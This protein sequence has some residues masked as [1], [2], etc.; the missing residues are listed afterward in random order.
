MSIR[1]TR[2]SMMMDIATIVAERSTCLRRQVGVVIALEGRILSMGYNGAPSG[3]THCEPRTCNSNAPC[4]NAIHAEANAIAWAA[5]H[6]V[7][8]KGAELYVTLSPCLSC[9]QL[10]VNSGV[11]RVY[12]RSLYRDSSGVVLIEDAGID[13]IHMP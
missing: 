3:M 12:Y 8:L 1:I 2:E 11:Q 4:T 5:R 10:I 13:I 9:A 7:A 6:G